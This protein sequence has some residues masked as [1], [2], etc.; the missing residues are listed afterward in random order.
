M[1]LPRNPEA[2]VRA[3][4]RRTKLRLGVAP[5][6]AAALLLTACGSSS[7]DE[8]SSS[9]ASSAPAASSASSES[10][11][12]ESASVPASASGGDLV[13]A[14]GALPPTLDPF[15]TQPTP[16]RSFTVSPLYSML[17]YVDAFSDG[18]PVGPGVAESWEMTNDTTWVFTL[19]PD[20]TF[21]N[22]EKLDATAV[23]FAVDYILDPVNESGIVA[24]IGPIASVDVVDPVTVQ[25][26]LTSPEFTLPRLL[27]LL[28]IVPPTDFTTRGSEAFFNSPVAAGL[29]SVEEFVPGESL[30]LVRNPDSVVGTAGPDSV[31]FQ[32]IV[33]DAS[34][35]AALK[36]GQVDVITK[37]P[38]DQIEGL[39]SDGLTT[40]AINEARLYNMDLYKSDGPLNDQRVRMALNMAVDTEGL[41]EAV[42]G[43]NGL[44]E[45]GQLSPPVAE[46]FCDTVTSI[47]FDVDGANQLMAEA[48]VSGLNLSIGTSQGFL[49]NDVLLAQAI[50]AQLE[51][52]DAVDTVDIQVMEYSNY[53]DVFYGRA[54]AQD[55][56]AWGMSSAPG[57]DIT[58]NLSRFTTT[59]SDRNPGGYSNPE[60]DAIY[61]QIRAT[62]TDDPKR[63]EL[64]C[65]AS[66]IVRDQALVLF[67]LYMP[68][69]W[70]MSPDVAGFRVDANG[71]PRWT[72]IGVTR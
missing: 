24:A 9:S 31:T 58:R 30:K 72:D 47:P 33:E 2:A 25:F 41:V 65:E 56:F 32:V 34:R 4:R 67:G 60:Y 28:P 57:L 16:P 37:V 36:S 6:V 45:Q 49:T 70:G 15:I 71:N 21:S 50:G 69:I 44:D 29:F 10:V 38:T 59:E 14:V 19:K 8:G 55:M 52:L 17:T 66:Q 11:G 39:D 64:Q 53:L 5:L 48:G 51:E 13:V 42:M 22:G 26:N 43:G 23:K 3:A 20:L 61:D 40:L 18:A 63:Q 54:P 27:S 12:S 68:D 1:A 35:I 62:A 7:S 46:G